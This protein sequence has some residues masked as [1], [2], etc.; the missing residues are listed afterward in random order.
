MI[1][2][3]LYLLLTTVVALPAA[4][5]TAMGLWMKAKQKQCTDRAPGDCLRQRDGVRHPPPWAT[6]NQM[7]TGPH[8]GTTSKRKATSSACSGGLNAF[9]KW[10]REFTESQ[11]IPGWKGPTRII[12][13]N[14]WL[15]TVPP[16][17][18]GSLWEQCPNTPWT[19]ALRAVPTALGSLFHAHPPLVQ[20]IS[21][22]L[23]CPSCHSQLNDHKSPFKIWF[24]M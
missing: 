7:A 20:T 5:W 22:T 18:K 21:L 13:S 17:R 11:N 15:H 4:S 6:L 23:S 9:I 2:V 3:V 1:K 12:T 16:K 19:P 24:P 10:G 14:P 8:A